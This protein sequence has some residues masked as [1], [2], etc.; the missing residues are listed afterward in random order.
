[1]CTHSSN[2][3]V[4]RT[5]AEIDFADVHLLKS[6]VEALGL[7]AEMV[8]QLGAHDPVREARIV[9]DI[10]GDHQLTTRDHT[11]EDQRVEIGARRVEGSGQPGR[12]RPDDYEL[13]VIHWFLRLV[14]SKGRS[15]PLPRELR[16]TPA[17]PPW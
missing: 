10:G 9:L 7:L 4:K 15:L 8:H 1:M 13:L 3:Q 14:S 17:L 16:P 11:L 5:R 12:A 6:G 2:L